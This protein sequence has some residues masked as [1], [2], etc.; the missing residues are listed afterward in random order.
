MLNFFT[1]AIIEDIIK[2]LD[3]GQQ[4]HIS[5]GCVN[6]SISSYK[7]EVEE[8]YS[9]GFTYKKK[10]YTFITTACI[11]P[12]EINL[13]DFESVDYEEWHGAIFIEVS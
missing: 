8:I 6:D 3:K 2:A 12:K 5:S 10:K 9:G 13:E 1:Q 7:E 4:V 11:F